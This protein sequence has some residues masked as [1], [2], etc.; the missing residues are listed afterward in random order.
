MGF[1]QGELFGE[2][3]RAEEGQAGGQSVPARP[4]TP[5]LKWHGGKAYLADWIISLMSPHL[6]YVEPFSGGGQV[7]VARDPADQRLWWPG[8][9]SDGR[10]CRGVSELVNDIDRNLMTFYA[11]L[12]DP[13]LFGRLQHRLDLTLFSEAEWQ[14]SCELLASGGGDPVER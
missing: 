9:A 6:H 8:Q 7:L 2:P 3:D 1:T 4:L 12:R 10:R 13:E 11:V 14:A 5:P